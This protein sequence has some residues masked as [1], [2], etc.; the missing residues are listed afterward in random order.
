MK[1][2][3]WRNIQKDCYIAL[4]LFLGA[5][6]VLGITGSIFLDLKAKI[7]SE[8]KV[9]DW[10]HEP[11]RESGNQLQEYW[12]C[13]RCDEKLDGYANDKFG[14]KWDRKRIE[15]MLERIKERNKQ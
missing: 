13:N 12:L 11:F 4:A 15:W 8:W 5:A 1:I 2:P 10:C 3:P 6:I 9:C 7:E 14:I